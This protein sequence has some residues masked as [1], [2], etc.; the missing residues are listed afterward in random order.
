MASTSVTVAKVKQ[1][2]KRAVELY[3]TT[4]TTPSGTGNVPDDFG[5]NEGKVLTATSTANTPTWQDVD[6]GFF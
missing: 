3:G 4:T 5:T 6:G 2:A 1:I